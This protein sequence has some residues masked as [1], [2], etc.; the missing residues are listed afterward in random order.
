MQILLEKDCINRSDV[1]FQSQFEI[2]S[3]CG[4]KW[5]KPLSIMSDY[6]VFVQ[7]F[8]EKKFLCQVKIFLVS[9]WIWISFF[10]RGS[11]VSR[12]VTSWSKLPSKM[13]LWIIRGATFRNGFHC[14]TSRKFSNMVLQNSTKCRSRAIQKTE[15]F[16]TFGLQLEWATTKPKP[17][18]L[19]TFRLAFFFWEGHFCWGVTYNLRSRWLQVASWS[20]HTYLRLQHLHGEQC[21]L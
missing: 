10:N 12:R 1:V 16:K 17:N 20:C 2:L 7:N 3:R 11:P 21:I 4:L 18:A 8:E 6:K 9:K 19:E 5:K 13:C 15:C 14:P